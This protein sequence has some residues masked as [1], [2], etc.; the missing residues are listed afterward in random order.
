VYMLA[1]LGIVCICQAL[2]LLIWHLFCLGM[3]IYLRRRVYPVMLESVG[4]AVEFRG[5]RAG[6][7]GKEAQGTVCRSYIIYKEAGIR[8]PKCYYASAPSGS[9]PDRKPGGTAFLFLHPRNRKFYTVD[10]DKEQNVIRVKNTV[11]A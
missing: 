10:N 4:V 11:N 6:A 9:I 8:N 5:S 1:V 3:R 7:E 2:Y